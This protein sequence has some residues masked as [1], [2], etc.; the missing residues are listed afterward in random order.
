VKAARRNGA[1][2]LVFLAPS[3]L[4]ETGGLDSVDRAYDSYLDFE[5]FRRSLDRFERASA[6]EVA[7]GDRLRA[8]LGR[9]GDTAG[10]RPDARDIATARRTGSAELGSQHGLAYPD[11]E[12]LR[13]TDTEGATD[14]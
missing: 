12:A 6:F 11:V 10:R 5:R 2:V 1:Q 13:P 4:Y 3:V 8:V 9:H 14:E 7:P